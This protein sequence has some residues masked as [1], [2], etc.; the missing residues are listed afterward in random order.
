MS[1][2][3]IHGVQDSLGGTP[4][5]DLLQLL[6][7]IT[8]IHTSDTTTL[9]HMMETCGELCGLHDATYVLVTIISFTRIMCKF[10]LWWHVHI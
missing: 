4:P 1:A 8:G 5:S 9:L 10:L 7:N 3:K 6:N 2:L